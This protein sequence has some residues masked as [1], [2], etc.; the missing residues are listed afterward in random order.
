MKLKDLIWPML[1]IFIVLMSIG[2]T[3]NDLQ[4]KQYRIAT[5]VHTINGKVWVFETKYNVH[6]GKISSRKQVSSKKY[7]N[8]K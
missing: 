8:I 2:A 3:S 7:R 1:V 5:D 4:P 6:S